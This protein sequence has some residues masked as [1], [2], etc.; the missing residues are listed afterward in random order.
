MVSEIDVTRGKSPIYSEGE[1]SSLYLDRRGNFWYAGWDLGL[2]RINPSTKR[3]DRY[4]PPLFRGMTPAPWSIAQGPGDPSGSERFVTEFGDS[5]LCGRSSSFLTSTLSNQQSPGSADGTL[6]MST[7][8]E[9]VIVHNPATGKTSRIVHDPSNPHSL[10]DN[11]ARAVLED[12]SRRIWVG[13]GK[14]L[15][16]WDPQT[17]SFQHFPN[18][19]FEKSLFAILL[20]SDLKGRIWIRYAPNGTSIFDPADS[21][22]AN[23]DVSSGV[24][25]AAYDMLALNDGRVV[26]TGWAGINIFHPDSLQY[27]RSAPSLVI[28][29]L[30]IN[31]WLFYFRH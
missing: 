20:G 24:C 2:Y 11:L 21:T 7:V 28:T 6:W 8:G 17:S 14:A 10:S 16:L 19:G 13:A 27:R 9:G 5:T 18:P 22:Y 30:V 26:L 25:G 3:V 4:T 15:N 12:P 31:N 23:F 29:Q 1:P